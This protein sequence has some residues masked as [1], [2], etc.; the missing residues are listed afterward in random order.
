[1]GPSRRGSVY[2][3]NAAQARTPLVLGLRDV[4]DEP[5]ALAPEWER[6]NVLPAL[7]ELYDELWVYGMKEI[8]DPFDGLDLPATVKLK[9]RYTGYLKRHVPTV[10]PHHNLIFQRIH[11][12]LS[13]QVVAEMVKA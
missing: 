11:L 4:M 1:M 5:A 7:E 6:K 13:Q 8:C 10:A 12:Y 9:T 2:H 3:G